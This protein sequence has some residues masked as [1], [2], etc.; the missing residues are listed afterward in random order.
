MIVL[1]FVW[2][3]SVLRSFARPD[4]RARV[5]AS[6]SMR[7]RLGHLKAITRREWPALMA[8][9][10]FILATSSLRNDLGTANTGHHCACTVPVRRGLPG[11]GLARSMNLV[12]PV[13]FVRDS[14]ASMG[15]A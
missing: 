9:E 10:V 15:S 1:R 12:E 4:M 8:I 14:R 3:P 13:V 6:R 11:R 7:L 2:S 5:E